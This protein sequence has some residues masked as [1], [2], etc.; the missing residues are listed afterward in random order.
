MWKLNGNRTKVRFEKRV[1]K[2]VSTDASAFRKTFKDGVT[3]ACD[4]VYGKMKSRKS[5]RD[6]CWWNKEVQDAI[7]RNKVQVSI[8]RK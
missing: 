6:M 3:N 7:A 1:K 5:R 8:R 2:L 4:E